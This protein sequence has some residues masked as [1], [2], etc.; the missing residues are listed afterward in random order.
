MIKNQKIYPFF[1]FLIFL[2]SCGYTPIFTS[3]NV[4]FKIVKY[5]ISGNEDLANDFVKRISR[6]QNNKSTDANEIFLSVDAELRKTSAIKDSTG[7][8]LTYKLDII[9]KAAVKR[10]GEDKILYA[11][12]LESSLNFDVQ[13]QIYD[14]NELEKIVTQNLLRKISTDLILRINQFVAQK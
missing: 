11:D 3:Q 1:I 8:I 6:S 13:D 5:E 10:I 4:E 12:T 14:T 2:V 7:K 9:I